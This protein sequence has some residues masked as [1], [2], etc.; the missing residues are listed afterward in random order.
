M[1]YDPSWTDAATLEP[2]VHH[3]RLPHLVELTQAVNRRLLLTYQAQRDYSSALAA[4]GY[5]RPQVFADAV[6]PPYDSLRLALDE[7]ILLA[8]PGGLGG[9]PPSPSAM[10]WLWP[11]DDGDLGKP[12]SAA[13]PPPTGSVSI[14][15][16]LN[17]SSSWTDPFL[18]GQNKFIRAAH[19]NELR[20]VIEW[21][22]MG[23][24]EMPVYLV[25][26]MH[27]QFPDTPW[28]GGVIANDGADECRLLGHAYIRTADAPP[29]G[30]AD[31]TVLEGSYIDLL[32]DFGCSVEV[33]A[34]LRDVEFVEDPPTWNQYDPSE[35]AYWA[36]PGGGGGADSQAI[37]TVFCPLGEWTRISGAAVASAVQGMIDGG[38]LVFL[39]RRANS[40]LEAI[41]VQARLGVRFELDAPP[42]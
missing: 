1:S 38:P 30:L 16:K 27:S 34:C 39:V 29:R 42:N 25:A 17:G 4:G 31:L 26:G 41:G 23:L 12:I 21:V 22:R 37:A 10:T 40:G 28:W 6:A 11:V 18:A 5:V 14:F 20:Q 32:V 13:T 19:L 35:A 24:W 7:K 36:T 9:N 8:P 2:G 33:R 3:V 15:A